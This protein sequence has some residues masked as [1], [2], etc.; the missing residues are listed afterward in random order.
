MILVVIEDN[1]FAPPF[2]SQAFFFRYIILQVILS[3]ISIV[4]R[5]LMIFAPSMRRRY[6]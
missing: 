1:P 2:K 5:Y 4:L 6:K 3:F